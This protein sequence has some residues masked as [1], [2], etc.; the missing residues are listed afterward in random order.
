MQV[1]RLLVAVLLSGSLFVGSD[2]FAKDSF[3][4]AK[5]RGA[6]L[7]AKG[8]MDGAIEA[9]EAAC[10]IKPDSYEVHLNLVNLFYKKGKI[11]RAISECRTLLKLKPKSKDAHIMMANLMRTSGQYKAAIEEFQKAIE[12]GAHDRPLY[13]AIGFSYLHEGDLE[14]AEEYLKKAATDKE[15]SMDA[16]IGLA[17]LDYRKKNYESA[18]SSLDKILVRKSDSTEARKLKGEVL[19]EL[20]RVDEAIIELEQVIAMNPGFRAAYMTLSNAYFQKKDLTK[21]EAILRRSLLLKKTDPDSH[22]ALGVIL[23]RQGRSIEAAG[24]F[25]TGAQADSNAASAA[26]MREHAVELRAQSISNVDAKQYSSL[27]NLGG[28]P[29]SETVFGLKFENLIK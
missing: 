26:R 2:A 17:I 3:K 4:S 16:L 22:Y 21:A 24:Q 11:E 18:L 29:N 15:P 23:D 13:S 12:I 14:K 20:G 6:Y 1:S 8:D 28:T 5:E 19:I 25:E 27:L 7:F 10:V 9:F